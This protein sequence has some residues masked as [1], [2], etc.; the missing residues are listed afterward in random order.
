MDG[1]TGAAGFFYII[2]SLQEKKGFFAPAVSCTGVP[3]GFNKALISANHNAR[4]NNKG[5]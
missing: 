5:A 2:M 3:G 4:P 1:D